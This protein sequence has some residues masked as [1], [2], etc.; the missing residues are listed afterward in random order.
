ME[1]EAANLLAAEDVKELTEDRHSQ[2]DSDS[3]SD[4]MHVCE[5]T[6]DSRHLAA[7]S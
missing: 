6:L 7:Q 2:L 3:H 4:V 5:M 1:E